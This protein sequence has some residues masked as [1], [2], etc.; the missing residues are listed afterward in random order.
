MSR[1]AKVFAFS[2][3]MAAL[4]LNGLALARE[5]GPRES[6]SRARDAAYLEAGGAALA[7]SLNYERRFVA[8]FGIRAGVGV[9]PLCLFRRC[10]AVVIV[11][12][13]ILTLVGEGSHHVELG[14]GFTAA[15]GMPIRSLACPQE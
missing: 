9:L 3:V 14:L 1:L 2:G 10:A 12:V 7:Y 13:S 8:A 6:E 11:P 15:L 5:T 4:S